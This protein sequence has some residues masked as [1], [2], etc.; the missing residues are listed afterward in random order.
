MHAVSLHMFGQG[1]KHLGFTGPDNGPGRHFGSCGCTR[2]P[3]L[4]LDYF[5]LIRSIKFLRGSLIFTV[6]IANFFSSFCFV[7]HMTPEHTVTNSYNQ[8]TTLHLS[9]PW[10]LSTLWKVPII[11]NI[12]Q[13]Q[14]LSAAWSILSLLELK[15]NHRLLLW[16]IWN[17]T[18][19]YTWDY[20]KTY[21]YI[22]VFKKIHISHLSF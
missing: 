2:F 7:L 3:H 9:G 20:S 22:S 8:P 10:H 13:T 12:T 14:T 5:L 6:W 19:S 4:S 18:I 16:T 11:P 1:S 17:H 15:A 21:S